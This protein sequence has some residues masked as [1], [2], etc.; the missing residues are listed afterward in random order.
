MLLSTMNI[1]NSHPSTYISLCLSLSLS[2]LFFLF[3][4]LSVSLSL[5]LS[6]SI[7]L[8]VWHPFQPIPAVILGFL[9][10]LQDLENY[11]SPRTLSLRT[12]HPD[13][14]KMS[15]VQRSIN[16][17]RRPEPSMSPSP[18]ILVKAHYGSWHYR[19]STSA[20]FTHFSNS[21]Q[22][23]VPLTP[24]FTSMPALPTHTQTHTCASK[25]KPKSVIYQ[26]KLD[27][28]RT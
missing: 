14:Q 12:G 18:A 26:A 24:T 19:S 8:L 10:W 27:V 3:I 15:T 22:H 6:L 1:S 25:R 21:V 9:C 17:L 5:S 20:R 23:Q 13:L 7:S 28:L 4:F 16:N 11:K 2:L